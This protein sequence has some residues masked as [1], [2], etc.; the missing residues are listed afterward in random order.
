MRILRHSAS[1]LLLHVAAGGLLGRVDL[2]GLVDTILVALV[3]LRR[4]EASLR[5]VRLALRQCQERCATLCSTY[6]DQVLS[7]GLGDEG[8]EF[9]RSKRVD[10]PSL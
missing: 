10:Q 2:V 9:R 7:L 5:Q 1:L 3:G 8:L 4:V 6:L